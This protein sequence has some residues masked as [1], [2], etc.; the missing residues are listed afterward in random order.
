MNSDQVLLSSCAWTLGRIVGADR[1]PPI[2][3]I[4]STLVPWLD[5]DDLDST[6]A[7]LAN[8]IG[9][10]SAELELALEEHEPRFEE[11][12]EDPWQ[13]MPCEVLERFGADVETVARR[14]DGAYYFHGTRAVDPEAFRRRGILPLDQMLEE[15][16]ATLRELAA[17]GI[18]DED[19]AVF[20]HDVETGIGGHDGWLYRHKVGAGIDLGPFGLLVRD[21]FLEPQSTGSHAYLG[22]PEIVQDISRCFS[23]VHGVNLEPR[24]CDAAKPC[25]VKFRSTQLRPGAINAALWCAYTKLRDGEITS[26]SNYS[27]DGNGEAVRAEDVMAV[28]IVS[29]I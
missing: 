23:S 26:S 15:L 29:T 1:L 17:D 2:A 24:F 16:W 19:W 22:C 3:H 8:V 7:S 27:F 12:A 13:L 4:V 10:T 28:E 18:S 20:R 14:F 6:V 9:V 21:I 5:C 11:A 25:I